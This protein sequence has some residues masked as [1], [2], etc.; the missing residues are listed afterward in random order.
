[1]A[2]ISR[3]DSL[4]KDIPA[5]ILNSQ[6]AV[7]APLEPLL[8]PDDPGFADQWHLDNVIFSGIDLNVTGLW[9]EYQGRGVV[10]GIVDT[11]ID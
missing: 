10:I 1:M 9:D 2:M 11:G 5:P 7:M 8:V 6:L 4:S 3:S